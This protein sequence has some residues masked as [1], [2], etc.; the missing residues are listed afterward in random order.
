[1][2]LVNKG[3][4]L[5][6]DLAHFNWGGSKT[7]ESDHKKLISGGYVK[8]GKLYVSL[9][10]ASGFKA[11]K[12][13]A[14]SDDQKNYRLVIDL[15]NKKAQKAATRKAIAPAAPAPVPAT[16]APVPA[17]VPASAPKATGEDFP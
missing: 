10:R 15:F 11:E 8:D 7:W 6:I 12:M 3:K 17:A 1:M 16:P 4:T 2:A 13:A 9:K 14:P 5:V